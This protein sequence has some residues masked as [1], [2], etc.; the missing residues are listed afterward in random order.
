MNRYALWQYLI[1]AV[2]IVLGLLY[3][4]PNFYGESPAVQISP[5]R[6]SL[7]ADTALL[8]KVEDALKEN[9]LTA[10]GVFLE[11]NSIKARFKDTDTQIKAKDSLQSALGND[12]ITALNLLPN[13]PQWLTS[14]GALPMYLGLDLRGGVHFMLAVD[15]QGALEKSLE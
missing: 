8:K 10:E 15:M 6:S 12:Y 1:I 3:T 11:G 13:S 9:S 14:L 4:L 5:L 7:T 2:S